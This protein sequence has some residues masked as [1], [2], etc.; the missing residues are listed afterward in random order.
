MPL[1][2]LDR[3]GVI[4]EDS[5]NFIRSL[6]DWRPIPGS[7]DAIARLSRGGFDIAIAT[8]QSGLGRGYFDLDQLETIHRHLCS[9]VETRGGEIK[10]IFYCPHH[11]KDACQCRKPATGLLSAIEIELGSS[12]RGAPCIGD[13]LRD[14]QAARAFGCSPILVRTGKGEQTLAQLMSSTP[15]VAD[16]ESIPVYRDLAEAASALLDDRAPKSD[17]S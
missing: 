12:A 2:I 6:A 7:L 14:L 11:P 1:L 9:E 17:M 16:A 4:N 15:T 5:D 8:N 10:G 3:D 13:S